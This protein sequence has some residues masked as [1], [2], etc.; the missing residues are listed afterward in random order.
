M[1][2]VQTSAFNG[3]VGD[4]VNQDMLEGGDVRYAV[5][6]PMWDTKEWKATKDVNDPY[7]DVPVSRTAQRSADANREKLYPGSQPGHNAYR[8]EY[9]ALATQ[10]TGATLDRTPPYIIMKVAPDRIQKLR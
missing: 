7:E 3:L 10:S 4:V 2:E 5:R 1:H 9:A 8:S 6:C